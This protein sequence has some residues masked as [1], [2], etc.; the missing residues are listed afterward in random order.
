MDFLN[1]LEAHWFWLLAGVLLGA[2][3][4]IVPGFF[5]IWFAAAAIITALLTAF[6]PIGIAVQIGLFAIL[7]VALVYVGRHWIVTNPIISSDPALNDRGARL[8]GEI[9]PVVDAITNGR[10]RVRVGDSD[11]NAR[12]TDAPIGAQVRVTGADG[13][14]LLVEP[15]N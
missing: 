8:R 1:T 5:L 4:I 12:G 9:V 10:G 7:A 15:L 3:E 14:T 2:A 13:A 6:L 11:W